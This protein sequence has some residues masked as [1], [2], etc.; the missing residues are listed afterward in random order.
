MMVAWWSEE[1][2]APGDW[3]GGDLGGGVWLGHK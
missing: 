3:G 2:L 1:E